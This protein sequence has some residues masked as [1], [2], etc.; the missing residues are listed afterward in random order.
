MLELIVGIDIG[1]TSTKF[2]LV[3]TSGKVRIHSSIATD[4]PDINAYIAELAKAIRNSV[5]SLDENVELIGVGVGAPNGNYKKGTIEDAPNL[6]WSGSIPIADLLESEF[7]LPVKLTNDANAAAMGE[8]MFG[9]AKGMQDF[10]TITLGTGLGS[11]FVANGQL[12]QGHDGHAGELGHIA[13]KI[14]GG[15]L[16]KCGKKGCLETYVSATGL[17]RTVYKLLAD[18]HMDSE[19]KRYSFDDLNT[20][21][22]ADAANNGDVVA[23]EA[24]E[25]TGKVLGAKLADAVGHT[26]PEAIFIMGGLAK[27][28]GL[29]FKPTI[30]HFEKN[31]LNVYQGKIKILPSE[32]DSTH[33][34][35][36]GA[37]SL[38]LEDIEN[39]KSIPV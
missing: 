8:M 4:N 14:G 6:P 38:I 13:Y 5:D 30:K 17:K 28:G 18:H 21:M 26:S 23:K 2:G 7:S 20:K 22:V 35:I 3:D 37:A 39:K 34:P 9:G 11:G 19:L 12:I 25:Y 27:A 31:L 29:I 24:F 10:I 1:G 15:R 32:L 36:I 33:T 16:C